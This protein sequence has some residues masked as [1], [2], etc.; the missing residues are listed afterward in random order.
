M[1]TIEVMTSRKVTIAVFKGACKLGFVFASCMAG[2]ASFRRTDFISD[3]LAAYLG[4]FSLPR[5]CRHQF[6]SWLL[7]T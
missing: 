3:S 5:I 6:V 4:G 2:L 1:L 7:E